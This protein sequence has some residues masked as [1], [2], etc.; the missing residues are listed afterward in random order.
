MTPTQRNNVRVSGQMAVSNPVIVFAHGFGCDQNLWRFVAREFE[1]THRVVV[2]DHVGAGN[3]DIS[4]YSP[5][6]YDALGAYAA[7]VLEI[8]AELGGPPVIFVGHSVGAMIGILAAI[9]QPERFSDLVLICPSPCYID[10]PGYTGGFSRE[11]IEEMLQVLESNYLGWSSSAAP[12]FMG[13]PDRPELGQELKE[14]F[15]RSNPEIARHFARVTFLSDHRAD[16]PLLQ[17]P[18]LILDCQDDFVAPPEVGRY[19]QSR[20][21]KGQLVTLDAT[22]HCPNLSAPAQTVAAI[23]SYLSR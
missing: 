8:V 22:G 15:C 16:L 17:T 7:D 6:K 5:A 13:N 3:S 20:I 19:V 1:A 12:A 23:R 4:A 10:E 2:F 11:Q 14:N 18:T 9:Q 21:A